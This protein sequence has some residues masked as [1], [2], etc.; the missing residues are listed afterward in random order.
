M[1]TFQVEP[2]FIDRD[3]FLDVGFATGPNGDETELTAE[4]EWGL[5]RRIG[6]VV[7]VPYARIDPSDAPTE[8]GFGDVAIAPRALL[9][10]SDRFLA[11]LNF[12]VAIPSG[13]G[14]RGLGAGE[15]GV[16]PSIS[17]WLDLGHSIQTNFQAGTEHGVS[18]G[19]AELFYRGSASW[20]FQSPSLFSGCP[21]ARVPGHFDP[22]MTSAI[23]EY[24][25]R[26]VL[27]GDGAGAHASE[28]LFGVSHVLTGFWEL[29]GG[30]R[31][32]LAGTREF[33]HGLILSAIYHF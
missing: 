11:S 15:T 17:L 16:A 12:E 4:L 10:E 1:H 6:L 13:D 23:V 32:P 27:H 28:M 30:Y 18:S 31:T 14:A 29:R 22:G 8:S 20:T 25:G 7:E 33:D 19:T 21:S 2:A 24:L 3:L 9:V 26:T 5:T